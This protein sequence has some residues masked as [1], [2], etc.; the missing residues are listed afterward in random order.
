M[1]A[2][3]GISSRVII[4][5]SSAERTCRHGRLYF[6]VYDV[7]RV[8]I[9]AITHSCAFAHTVMSGKWHVKAEVSLTLAFY[10]SQISKCILSAD[11]ACRCHLSLNIVIR[12]IAALSISHSHPTKHQASSP[13]FSLVFRIDSVILCSTYHVV[14][15][16]LWHWL[17]LLSPVST[18][19]LSNVECYSLL[20][21]DYDFGD[22]F[23]V[24]QSLPSADWEG[25][26]LVN[27]PSPALPCL[28]PSFPSYCLACLCLKHAGYST[29]KNC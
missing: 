17:S 24:L 1:S 26:T 22:I 18:P 27:P 6:G 13:F 12:V 20:F 3:C 15:L 23:P 10:Y 2:V 29:S 14:L 9:S 4:F 25:G 28:L 16:F 21:L 5:C 7:I 8:H 11:L 19:P